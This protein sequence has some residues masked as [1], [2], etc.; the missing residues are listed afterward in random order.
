[1]AKPIVNIRR[2]KLKKELPMGFR[3]WRIAPKLQQWG[4]NLHTVTIKW[5]NGKLASFL[6]SWQFR[7]LILGPH[8]FT[9][10][11]PMKSYSRK[12]AASNQTPGAIRKGTNESICISGNNFWSV[13]FTQRQQNWILQRCDGGG[14]AVVRGGGRTR[15]RAVWV[16]DPLPLVR[17]NC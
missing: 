15:K 10:D 2:L 1:M 13:P 6:L 17:F 3:V 14:G 4:Q 16:L 9:P 7:C 5:I 12:P 11:Q 8:Q